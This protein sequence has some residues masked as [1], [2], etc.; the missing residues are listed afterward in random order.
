MIR[1]RRPFKGGDDAAPLWIISF[2]DLQAQIVVFF[3]L[4]L[5]FSTLDP[6]RVSQIGA[7]FTGSSGRENPPP[8]DDF[9][10][11]WVMTHQVATPAGKP[12]AEP[13]GPEGREFL[14]W[15]TRDGLR[16]S[17]ERSVS[18]D[19]GSAAIQADQVDAI[20]AFQRFMRGSLNKLDIRGFTGPDEEPAVGTHWS[21][22]AARAQAVADLLM[23]DSGEPGIDPAR[24]RVTGMG[25]N[26][27]VV[28]ILE[29]RDPFQ[30]QRNRR[31]EIIVLEEKAQVK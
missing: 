28:D 5:S 31:V 11:W 27:P 6:L 20:R 23:S 4:L 21:L 18:F 16:I 14:V 8:R 29:V 17:L 10:V 1:P 2:S 7:S 24:I 15:R 25:R 26:D 22:S 30:W 13:W 12:V 9:I 19:P 3:A